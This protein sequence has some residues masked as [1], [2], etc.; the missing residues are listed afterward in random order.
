MNIVRPQKILFNN[1]RK[2]EN[3]VDEINAKEE[4]DNICIEN[5]I[6]EKLE[7]IDIKIEKADDKTYYVDVPA[8]GFAIFEYRS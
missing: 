8:A 7:L 1:L 3:L 2:I 5:Y 4:L 6:E